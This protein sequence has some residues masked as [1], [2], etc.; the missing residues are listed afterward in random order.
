MLVAMV[1]KAEGHVGPRILVV[2]GFP[3]L[4]HS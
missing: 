4:V 3:G 1:L 2:V